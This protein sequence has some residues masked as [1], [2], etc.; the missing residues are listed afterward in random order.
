MSE[1]LVFGA[2]AIALGGLIVWL[3]QQRSYWKGAYLAEQDSLYAAVDRAGEAERE[4]Q[5]AQTELEY[6]KK[7][8]VSLHN[9]PVVAVL[10][11]QQMNGLIQ[12]VVGFIGS[13]TLNPK[14]MS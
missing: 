8:I 7:F 6:L 1:K 9:K 12:S 13:A 2:L 14:D 3:I 11:D 5:E 10:N 4:A